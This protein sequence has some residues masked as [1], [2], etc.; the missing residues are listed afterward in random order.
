MA[1][2]YFSDGDGVTLVAPYDV[3][4]G[5]GC[6]VST[7][8]GVAQ[9]DALTGQTL[10]IQVT[11]EWILKAEGAVSGQARAIGDIVYWDNTAK[12]CT[13]TSAGNR[14]IGNCTYAKAT[15]ATD[16]RVRLALQI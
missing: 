10:T 14:A 11:G 4:S 16:V 8:F 1:K 2:N 12:Q 13:V 9:H 3:V 6:L 7:L 5:A 15:A